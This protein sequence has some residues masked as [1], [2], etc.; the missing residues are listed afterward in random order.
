MDKNCF[1]LDASNY[2]TRLIAS[3]FRSVRPSVGVDGISL[4]FVLEYFSNMS[5]KFKF[6]LN[7][8]RKRLFDMMIYG[9]YLLN[10]AFS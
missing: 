8:E 1:L 4:N 9:Y 7:L 5:G 10:L 6:R 2:E 3:S